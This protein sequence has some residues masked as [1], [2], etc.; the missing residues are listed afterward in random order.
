[1][2]RNLVKILTFEE[3]NHINKLDATSHTKSATAMLVLHEVC[4]HVLLGQGITDLMLEDQFQFIDL[5]QE[6]QYEAYCDDF[7]PMNMYSTISFVRLK[8]FQRQQSKQ[9]N[10]SP[11][12]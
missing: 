4:D 5:S 11:R 8:D 3:Q 9:Q 2:L 1:M 10:C 7:G 12:R 6:L